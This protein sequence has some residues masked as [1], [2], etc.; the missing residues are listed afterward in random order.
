MPSRQK[1]TIPRGRGGIP[2]AW[3]R[4]LGGGGERREALPM[5]ALRSPEATRASFMA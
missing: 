3:E 4:M 1:H 5:L 2:G